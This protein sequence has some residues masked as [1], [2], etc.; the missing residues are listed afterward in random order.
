MSRCPGSSAVLHTTRKM[1]ASPASDTHALRP[2]TR[3][4]SPV[5]RAARVVI[6]VASEPAC[7]SVSENP[8]SALAGRQAAR[9][10]RAS[11]SA[12]RSRRRPRPRRC[13][14]RART[15]TPRRRGPAPR[16]PACR[17]GTPD[18]RPPSA[19]GRRA[20][21]RPDAAASLAR[22]ASAPAPSRR[23]PGVTCRDERPARA[24]VARRSAWRS[25][26]AACLGRALL[27]PYGVLETGASRCSTT[28]VARHGLP[29]DEVPGVGD[30]G[31]AEVGH[32]L[33][34]APSRARCGRW[35][36]RSTSPSA[37]TARCTPTTTCSRASRWATRWR[38]R[39]RRCDA[40]L[41]VLRRGGHSRR[42]S[43]RSPTR[44]LLE[45]LERWF[46]GH[47]PRAERPAR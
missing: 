41:E 32:D 10:S 23:T 43:S 45:P 19:P 44:E 5:R 47:S 26:G 3:Q 15:R 24:T 46:F 30:D 7:G 21:V 29:S 38:P 6:A 2:V 8:P 12:S 37:P 16:T 11:I 14:S 20:P 18:R 28:E 42:R 9:P 35:A 31:A 33:D 25:Y 22:V 27:L 1:S 4:L 36:G 17:R 13:A 39:T 40:D 34:R